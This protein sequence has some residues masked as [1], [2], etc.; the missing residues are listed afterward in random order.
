MLEPV[1]HRRQ[2]GHQ[3]FVAAGWALIVKPAREASRHAGLHRAQ[4][5]G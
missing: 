2:P 3:Q 5:T 1:P 4:P